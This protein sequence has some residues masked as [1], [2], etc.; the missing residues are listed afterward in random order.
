MRF[1]LQFN[2]SELLA[3]FMPETVCR[4]IASWEHFALEALKSLDLSKSESLKS[5]HLLLTISKP[6]KILNLA[7]AVQKLWIITQFRLQKEPFPTV[8]CPSTLGTPPLN[9]RNRSKA[10]RLKINIWGSM[11]LD[12]R[13]CSEWRGAPNVDYRNRRCVKPSLRI[14]KFGLRSSFCFGWSPAD[15]RSSVIK[16]KRP[17]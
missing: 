5:F 16:I 13:S 6:P 8:K 1:R 9:R 11:E 4:F 10:Q 15:I 14:P 12:T 17:F 7:I 3:G 2:N